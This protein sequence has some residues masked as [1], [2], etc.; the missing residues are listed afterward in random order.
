MAVDTGAVTEATATPLTAAV[1]V[2]TMM[3]F[4]TTTAIAGT[5]NERNELDPKFVPKSKTEAV[6][7]LAE[8]L[9]VRDPGAL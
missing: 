6:I 8:F 2:H 4:S 7:S 9:V 1:T 5:V 3:V